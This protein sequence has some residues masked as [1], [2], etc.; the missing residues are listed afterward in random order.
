MSHPYDAIVI[1]A[2]HK[3][4]NVC[5]LSGQDGAKNPFRCNYVLVNLFHHIQQQEIC[6]GR[7]VSAKA[8]L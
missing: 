8:S 7:L 3:W 5:M 4:L 6:S 1:G 2:G